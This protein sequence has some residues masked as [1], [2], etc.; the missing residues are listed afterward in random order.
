MIRLVLHEL[1]K[2]NGSQ[3]AI[4]KDKKL[5]DFEHPWVIKYM[6]NFRHFADKKNKNQKNGNKRKIS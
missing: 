3:E 5:K 4:K 6:K 1:K 2:E